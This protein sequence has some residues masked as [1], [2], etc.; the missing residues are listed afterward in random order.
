[1]VSAVYAAAMRRRRKR[2]A[3]RPDLRRRLRRPVISIGNLAVGGRGKTPLTASIA[4]LLHEAGESPAILTRG[5]GRARPEKHVVVVRDAEGIRADLGRSGDEPLMLA[6]QLPGTAVLVCADRYEAGMFAEEHLGSTIHLLDDGFQHLRLHR[7]VDLLIVSRADLERPVTLPSGRLRE[8]LDAMAAADAVLTM[9]DEVEG[10]AKALTLRVFRVRR[11]G[12]AEAG[13][14]EPVLALAGIAGP[15]RF[16][17][18]LAA[19]GWNVAA[20]MVF[21]DHHRYTARDLSRMAD[22][23]RRSGAVRLVTTEKDYVRLLPFRPFP[24]P[25]V[26]IPIRLEPDPRDEFRRWL[27]EELARV[28][29]EAHG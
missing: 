6:R 1:M 22:A 14:G 23:A 20:R 11:E 19:G 4:R 15:G 13:T 16:F 18:D 12:R 26:F 27:C 7:D 21:A 3:S 8:S 5:Y 29:G 25:V 17:D 10:R 9:D 28:R 24:V 2:Y